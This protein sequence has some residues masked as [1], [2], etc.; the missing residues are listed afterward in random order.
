MAWFKTV[1]FYDYTK[2]ANRSSLPANYAL[3]FS[4]SESNESDARAVL[5]RGGNVAV[6]FRRKASF[7]PMYLGAPTIDGDRHDLRFLD[8]VG[9][10]VAL[11][12]KGNA[13]RDR[14]GFVRD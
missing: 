6:V 8:P 4:L 5:A 3:T 2:R 7:P 13:K 14:S 12:A 11:Y 10:V 1:Q 9:S